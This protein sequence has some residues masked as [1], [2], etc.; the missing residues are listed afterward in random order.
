M[1]IAQRMN[2]NVNPA[3]VYQPI[4]F[5]MALHIAQINQMKHLRVV[6]QAVAHHLVFGVAM[7]HVW[8]TK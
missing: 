2:I 1:E 5:V 7:V 6:L 4:I 8:I 3:S